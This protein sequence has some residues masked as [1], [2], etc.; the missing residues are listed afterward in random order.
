VTLLLVFCIGLVAGPA[1]A[2]RWVAV[3]DVATGQEP[4]AK[5]T[6][7]CRIENDWNNA[8]P[9]TAVFWSFGGWCLQDE[10]TTYFSLQSST[11]LAGCLGYPGMWIES[12]EM[13]LRVIGT[14]CN[15][16]YPITTYPVDAMFQIY[17]PDPALSTPDC[18]VP[19]IDP[20]STSVVVT[21]PA[22]TATASTDP[23]R[24]YNV[25]C[26]LD[27][28]CYIALQPVFGSFKYVAYSLPESSLVDC[29]DGGTSAC[30][31]WYPAFRGRNGTNPPTECATPCTQYYRNVA[32]Y[33]PDWYESLDAGL[34]RQ[35]DFTMWLNVS[36]WGCPVGVEM[37][38]WG[39]L[40]SLMNE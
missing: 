19:A 10:V 38:T 7:Q 22:L 6:A 36:C 30:A 40:K 4:A 39:K 2:G 14:T 9:C 29:G 5:T 23:R 11:C 24:S 37:T 3:P 33:G 34:G 1:A 27:P 28:M 17:Q 25:V 21:I 31:W 16:G 15:G 32:V 20:I 12:G 26:P 18:P 8:S 13:G 35:A